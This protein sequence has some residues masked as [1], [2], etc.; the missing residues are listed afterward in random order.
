MDRKTRVS[1]RPAGVSQAGLAQIHPLKNRLAWLGYLA[2]ALTWVLTALVNL[3]G[4]AGLGFLILDARGNAMVIVLFALVS[5]G[6]VASAVLACKR[7]IYWAWAGLALAWAP[8]LL[9]ASASALRSF[10]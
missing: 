3:V 1:E 8:S 4:L 10:S 7:R 9:P 6:L 5:G 2:F